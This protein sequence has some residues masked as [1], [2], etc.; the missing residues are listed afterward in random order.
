[1]FLTEIC[2]KSYVCLSVFLIC[3][4][5]QVNSMRFIP[6]YHHCSDW[7]N[8]ENVCLYNVLNEISL[9]MLQ[10]VFLHM[11]TDVVWK[12]LKHWNWN[13]DDRRLKLYS[14]ADCFLQEFLWYFSS[15][16]F[17][18]SS[19]NSSRISIGITTGTHSKFLQVFL[20]DISRNSFEN[21]PKILPGI[22][23]E[24]LPGISA[25]TL[26]W[27]PPDIPSERTFLQEPL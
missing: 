1:M 2:T 22:P 4:N 3:I 12:D 23:S 21:S 13:T 27:I 11:N 26:P 8:S 18:D 14:S 24:I 5:S 15:D 17:R 25:K 19:W 20:W 9:G 7:I 10:M 6:S 16:S